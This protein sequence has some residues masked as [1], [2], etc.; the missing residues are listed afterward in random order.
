MYVLL[1]A[2]DVS[3]HHCLETR[4]NHLTQMKKEMVAMVAN[5]YV[6]M[7]IGTCDVRGVSGGGRE[8]KG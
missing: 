1:S 8:G 6:A 4:V 2:V 3:L 7:V 5:V